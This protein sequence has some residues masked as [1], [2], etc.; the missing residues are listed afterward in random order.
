MATL[1]K[2]RAE[3]ATAAEAVAGDLRAQVAATQ[4]LLA[5]AN[6]RAETLEGASGDA[7]TVVADLQTRIVAAAASL[8]AAHADTARVTEQA[9]GEKAAALA[10][11]EEGAVLRVAAA[12]DAATTAAMAAAALEAEAV[13]YTMDMEKETLNAE[14]NARADSEVW[15]SE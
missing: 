14:W 9:A 8:E 10:S 3:G 11:A 7:E 12:A 13:L 4:Q 1:A 2:E 15:A 6:V 5:D